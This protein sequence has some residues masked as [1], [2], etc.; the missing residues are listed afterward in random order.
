MSDSEAYNGWANRET[1]AFHLWV[2]NDSGMYET[3]RESVEEFAY[4]CDEMSNWR[5]G[6]FVVEWVKDLLEECGQAGGDM[7]RE[8]GSW[9]RVD[10]REIGAAMREAYIS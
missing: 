8:I 10:E 1:W 3:L 9:W 4:N 6:E 7:Y 5:L 2:S